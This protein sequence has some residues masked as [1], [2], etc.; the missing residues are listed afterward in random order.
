M[1]SVYDEPD[2]SSTAVNRCA[3]AAD[4]NAT[5]SELYY[6]VKNSW[7]TSWGIDGYI[8]M[9]RNKNNQCGIATM[10]SYPRFK[11]LQPIFY[12]I[13]NFNVYLVN[14]YNTQYF[15]MN[16]STTKVSVRLN[17]RVESISTTF[18]VNIIHATKDIWHNIRFHNNRFAI[19]ITSLDLIAVV[20]N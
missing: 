15:L 9:S 16:S 7:E 6:I 10:T 17:D 4:F 18:N 13:N 3:L 12:C 19:L 5:D 20:D 11:N 8:W 2:Y 14:L 1:K